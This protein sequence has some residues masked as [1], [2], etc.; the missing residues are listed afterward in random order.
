MYVTAFGIE[1]VN[2]L[3]LNYTSRSVN[4]NFLTTQLTTKL[5]IA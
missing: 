2:W 1:F 4:R 3:F 5:V